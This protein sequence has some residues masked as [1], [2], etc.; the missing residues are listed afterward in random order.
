MESNKS[1]RDGFTQLLQTEWANF[2]A[3]RGRVIG[4]SVSALVTE[5]LVIW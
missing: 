5:S 3:V 4:M 2:W 1:E